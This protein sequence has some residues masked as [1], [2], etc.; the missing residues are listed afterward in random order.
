MPFIA[1]KRWLTKRFFFFSYC[2]G[3]SRHCPENWTADEGMV[4]T[5]VELANWR[6]HEVSGTSA[7][8]PTSS[9]GTAIHR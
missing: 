8:C 4:T 1:S 6:W 2:T 9:A 7:S 3:L 5:H